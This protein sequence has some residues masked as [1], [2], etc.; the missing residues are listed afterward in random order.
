M[1]DYRSLHGF[2]NIPII[3]RLVTLDSESNT[4]RLVHYTTQ[5]Y[6]ERNPLRPTPSA[7]VAITQSLIAY[8][9]LR[10]LQ[11]GPCADNEA[12]EQRFQRYPLLRYASQN[13]GTHARGLPESSC[14]DKILQL[15]SSNPLL[16]SVSQAATARDDKPPSLTS[17]R[18]SQVY[19]TQISVLSAVAIEGLTSIVEH[20][21]GQGVDFEEANDFGATALI[22]AAQRGHPATIKALLKAGANIHRADV[23]GKTALIT[24]A[25]NGHEAAVAALLGGKPNVEAQ[26]VQDYTALFLAV[27]FGHQCTALLLLDAGADIEAKCNINAAAVDSGNSD[28]IRLISQRTT[29]A[30]TERN[31]KSSVL[32]YMWSNRGGQTIEVIDTLIKEGGDINYRSDDG[33][34][35][36]HLA[37]QKG[38]MEPVNIFLGYGVDPNTRSLAGNTP[39]HCE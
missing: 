34:T 29:T 5:E 13:W 6:F 25:G 35:P 20:L 10:P 18:W 23:S 2:A 33:D 31:M 36:L 27:R 19:R 15:L 11:Q 28:I 30:L 39:L 14:K 3:Q 26:T 17:L 24:A 9:S 37:A 4:V 21:L 8:L 12:L 32:D 7:Q 1:N 38:F 22:L 16:A